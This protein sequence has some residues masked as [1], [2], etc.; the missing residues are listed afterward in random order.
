MRIP[1]IAELELGAQ[2]CGRTLRLC[3]AHIDVAPRRAA[4][5]RQDVQDVA[6]GAMLGQRSSSTDLDI[7][8]VR[9]DREDASLL[10]LATVAPR[11]RE[12]QGLLHE[13]GRCH[14]F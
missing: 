3:R 10:L 2:K 7:V 5:K 11:L 12:Q 4:G 13:L 8:G 1:Q 9:A 14:G 6:T